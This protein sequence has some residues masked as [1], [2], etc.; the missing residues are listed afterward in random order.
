MNTKR[1]GQTETFNSKHLDLNQIPSKPDIRLLNMNVDQKELQMKI[2]IKGL[3]K[4]FYQ[5]EFHGNY[6]IVSAL[7]YLSKP[8][9]DSTKLKCEPTTHTASFFLPCEIIDSQVLSTAEDGI[10]TVKA[11]VLNKDNRKLKFMKGMNSD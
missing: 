2:Q 1:T 3:W 11:P 4:N 7:K 9:C 6:L 10:I 5:L 8:Y